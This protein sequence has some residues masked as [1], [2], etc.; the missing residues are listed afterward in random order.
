MPTTVAERPPRTHANAHR[1]TTAALRIDAKNLG[2]PQDSKTF[3]ALVREAMR[4]TDL[5]QK[6]FALNAGQSESVISE[7]LSG[8]RHLAAEWVWAPGQPDV[9]IEKLIS[10]IKIERGLADANEEKLFADLVGQLVSAVLKHGFAR[11]ARAGV[12]AL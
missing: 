11:R 2:S 5:S 10:L 9:F 4:L 3:R 12:G 8:S 7:A 6:A 1:I